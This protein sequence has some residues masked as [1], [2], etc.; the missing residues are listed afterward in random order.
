MPLIEW[1]NDRRVT[2]DV[3]DFL[4]YWLT[5]HILKDDKNYVPFLTGQAEAAQ[6]DETMPTD[7][8]APMDE[9]ETTTEV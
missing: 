9:S 8:A 4:K 6:S 3:R 7:E 5:S 1:T 2:G